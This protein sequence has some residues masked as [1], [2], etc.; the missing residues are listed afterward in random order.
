MPELWNS[1]NSGFLD[2]RSLDFRCAVILEMFD[3]GVVLF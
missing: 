3:V 2:R 1:T